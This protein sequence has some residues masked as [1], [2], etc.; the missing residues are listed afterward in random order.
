LIP[1]FILLF[2]APELFSLVF[3]KEWYVSGEYA[4]KI[5]VMI[6]F[7]LIFAPSGK[8]YI[9]FEKQRIRLILDI[10]RVVLVLMVFGI[11]RL[12]NFD[13]Y[14]TISCYS[15]VMSIN[16][17]IM[18]LVARKILNNEVKKLNL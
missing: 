6:F 1:L 3:G 4:S 2:F 5:S 12:N 7:M 18:H 8:I 11:S 14:L 10:L 15:I 13:S 9:V 16:F 17:L